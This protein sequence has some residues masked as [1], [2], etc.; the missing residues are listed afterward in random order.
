MQEHVDLVSHIDGKDPLLFLS[1]LI[2]H[3]KSS[4]RERKWKMQRGGQEK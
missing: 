3:N 4:A 2:G 1:G